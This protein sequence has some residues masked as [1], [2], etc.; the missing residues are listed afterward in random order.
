MTSTRGSWLKRI[1]GVVLIVVGVLA[2]AG[3]FVWRSQAVPRLVKY[4]T[5][6]DETPM[7]AGS[8]T[9]YLNQKTYAP[10]AWPRA[11]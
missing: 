1:I 9:I 2:F 4:P 8:V 7:Y 6:V 5:D 10:L 11:S 3:S